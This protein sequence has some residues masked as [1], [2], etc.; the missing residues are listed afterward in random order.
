MHPF[1]EPALCCSGLY[2][3][4]KVD[5]SRAKAGK[6]LDLS[7]LSHMTSTDRP[8]SMLTVTPKYNLEFPFNLTF[9]F[10]DL[11]MKPENFYLHLCTR[12]PCKP[13]EKLSGT[14]YLLAVR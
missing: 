7:Q 13:H 6:T 2:G 12:R 14:T 3:G 8:P 9:P 4:L 5:T 11:V 10:L 1:S